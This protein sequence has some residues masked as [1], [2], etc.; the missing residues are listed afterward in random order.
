[1]MPMAVPS[2]VTTQDPLLQHPPTHKRTSQSM[3]SACVQSSPDRSATDTRTR[4]EKQGQL[5]GTRPRRKLE[6]PRWPEKRGFSGRRGK[7]ARERRRRR[8]RQWAKHWPRKRKRQRQ[9]GRHGTHGTLI[10]RGR[11]QSELPTRS[12]TSRKSKNKSMSISMSKAPPQS[13]PLPL[14]RRGR[15]P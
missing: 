6:R 13:L 7:R 9:H 11:G 8:S 2:R 3:T 14:G 15:L 10:R 4:R 5:L 1:M 12:Q